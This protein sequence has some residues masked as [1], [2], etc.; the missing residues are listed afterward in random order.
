MSTS[1][2]NITKIGWTKKQNE[3]LIK[4][5]IQSTQYEG[6]ASSIDP[7]TTFASIH[8]QMATIPSQKCPYCKWQPCASYGKTFCNPLLDPQPACS[9]QYCWVPLH[10][11]PLSCE[12]ID[13]FNGAQSLLHNG[14]CFS[15]LHVWL[16]R[17][18]KKVFSVDHSRYDQ[19]K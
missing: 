2:S 4:K 18:I 16:F 17:Q 5:H 11:C 12:W 19:E 8:H 15:I 1:S 7:T 3:R 9:L 10:N 14:V 13:C 6:D